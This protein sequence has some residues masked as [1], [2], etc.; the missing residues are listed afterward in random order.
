MPQLLEGTT[1]IIN[2]LSRGRETGGHGL[3]QGWQV[4]RVTRR[5][6]RCGVQTAG[7]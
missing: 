3:G 2:A 7:P 1:V 6:S 5:Y 4:G